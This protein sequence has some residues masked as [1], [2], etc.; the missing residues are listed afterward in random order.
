MITKP[1]RNV[2]RKK[3]HGRVRKNLTGT[4]AR[5]RLNVYRSNK[6]IYAQ[7]IDDNNGVTLAS[8]S[9]KDK[10]LNVEVTSNVDAAKKVGEMVAKR[11]QEKGVKSVVF[12]RGGYLYHGRIKALAEAAREAGLEF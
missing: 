6:N 12:D 10:E 2:L 7:I 8:A 5:P 3:R 11:A 1:D 9:T 4:E